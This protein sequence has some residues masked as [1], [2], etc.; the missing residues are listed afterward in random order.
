M[1]T[2]GWPGIQGDADLSSVDPSPIMTCP[3][4]TV[5]SAI[6]DINFSNSG[7]VVTE[8]G[9]GPGPVGIGNG[10]VASTVGCDDSIGLVSELNGQ[11]VEIV[12]VGKCAVIL[13]DRDGGIL[14]SSS[15][16]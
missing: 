16:L 3:K 9:T 7:F 12:V 4:L 5:F 8:S 13:A 1:A 15:S 10:E 6:S 2:A 14:S 11:G